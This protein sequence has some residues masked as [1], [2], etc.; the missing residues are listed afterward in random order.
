MGKEFEAQHFKRPKT[1]SYNGWVLLEA[2]LEMVNPPK[3]VMRKAFT[4][5]EISDH[6]NQDLYHS[7]V[8]N[9]K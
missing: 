5:G 2:L 4:L 9:H 8:V 7:Q 3:K 6:H 1:Y